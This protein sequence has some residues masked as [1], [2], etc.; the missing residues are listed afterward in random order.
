[1]DQYNSQVDNQQIRGMQASQSTNLIQNDMTAETIQNT[2]EA[3][4]YFNA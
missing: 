4:P 1:M 2:I 3:N